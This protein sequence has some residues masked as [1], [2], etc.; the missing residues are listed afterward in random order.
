MATSEHRKLYQQVV[1]DHYRRPRNHR[2]L[3]APARSVEMCNVLC[4]DQVTVF[5][6]V[7][8]GVLQEITFQGDG[9]ALCI[10]SASLM[11]EAL[12]GKTQ[13][14]AGDKIAAFFGLATATGDATE[15]AELGDL[16]LF[17]AVREFPARLKCVT[18]AWQTV[19]P[20]LALPA[21]WAPAAS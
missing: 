4:G 21:A 18:L 3:E 10:A 1:L 16:R 8:D 13:D 12:R 7:V 9:C 17:E 14:E 20:M 6:L 2:R 11:T 5:T 19:Q 15:R